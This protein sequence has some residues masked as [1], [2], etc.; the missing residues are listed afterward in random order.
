MGGGGKKGGGQASQIPSEGTSLANPISYYRSRTGRFPAN[1]Q[2]WWSMKR[3]LEA[4]T[5]RPPRGYLEAFDPGLRH[6]FN[7]GNTPAPKGHYILQAFNKDRSSASGV[8]NLQRVTSFG[9]RPRAVAFYAGRVFYGGAH[10]AGFNNIIYFSQ[11]IENDRQYGRCYQEADPTAEEIRDLLPT[12][13]G[14]VLVPEIEEIIHMQQI[15]MELYVFCSNGIWRIAGSEG[16]GFRA[17]DY[18][19]M[20]ISGTPALS[21]YSFIDIEGVPMW[22]NRTGI[23]TMAPGEGGQINIQSL[24]EETIQEL[25]DAI[26]EDSKY[27]AKGAYDP[28]KKRVE[29]LYRHHPASNEQDHFKYDSI[30]TLDTR[31]GAWSPW[32]ISAHPLVEVKGIFTIAGWAVETE[33]LPVV[34]GDEVVYVNDLSV[35]AL[36][37]HR[38]LVQG[39]TKYIV[40][41]ADG[42]DVVP[43]PP[44]PSPIEDIEVFVLDQELFVNTERVVYTP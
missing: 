25:Y 23:Y 4:G 17:N 7:V 27:Y 6:Q 3:P 34:A 33:L 16:L 14:K 12:D 28:V 44:P 42:G 29:F 39:K 8:P 41:V 10:T 37:E 35:T 30:L 18:S 43:P 1:S 19:V 13:G 2:I 9:R 5:D 38:R 22:W 20:K 26:P 11:V 36:E 24:T 21:S 31:T 32:R 15:G 40:D